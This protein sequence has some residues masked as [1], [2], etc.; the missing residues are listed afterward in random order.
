MCEVVSAEAV[1]LFEAPFKVDGTFFGEGGDMGLDAGC[2]SLD[3]VGV[4]R[5]HGIGYINEEDLSKF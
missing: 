5:G 1:V 3:C 2:E 4:D